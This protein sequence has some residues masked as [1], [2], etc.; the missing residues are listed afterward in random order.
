MALKNIGVIGTGSW[1]SALGLHLYDL[2]NNVTFWE[3]DE[4]RVKTIHET[5]INDLLPIRPFPS[6]LC[7]THELKPVVENKDILI[8][9][10]PSHAMRSVCR[11]VNALSLTGNPLIVN[12][13]KG[14]ETETLMRMSEVIAHEITFPVRGILTVTGPSHAEEVVRK[15]PTVLVAACENES[16]S[17]EI[18]LLLMDERLRIYTTND[19]TGVELGGS[20]KNVIAI[21]AGISDG[22]GFGDNAKAALIVRGAYE[23]MKIGLAMGARPETFSGLTGMGDLIVTCISKHS[24]NRYVGEELG[25]GR[26]L[27]DIL[28]PM[29]MVAEGVTTTRSAIRLAEKYQAEMPVAKAVYDVMFNNANPLQQVNELMLRDPKAELSGSRSG[30]R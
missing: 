5:R 8:F 13:S 30:S 27:D 10:V 9:A 24:R 15:M 19:L 25:K 4:N 20:L 18:Q 14:I 6:E 12:I 28:K 16:L 17:E 7:V 11:D 22:V 3:F 1:G 21:A 29:K 23:I 2:G 26:K